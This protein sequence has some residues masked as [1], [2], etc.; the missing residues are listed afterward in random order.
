MYESSGDP[1]EFALWDEGEPSNHDGQEHCVEV[2]TIKDG[3][4]NDIPCSWKVG[5][6]CQ[7]QAHQSNQTRPSSGQ[8]EIMFDCYRTD[9]LTRFA[10]TLKISNFVNAF[11]LS[12]EPPLWA[13][14]GVLWIPQMEP[15][16]VRV[17]SSVWLRL[18]SINW[19]SPPSMSAVIKAGLG[20]GQTS[21]SII[22]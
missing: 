7:N 20:P 6:V 2:V 3:K 18:G 15:W 10:V 14:M 21:T 9:K 19:R 13:M 16:I 5:F 11:I 17:A 8:K 1:I 22:Q 4:W 12:T